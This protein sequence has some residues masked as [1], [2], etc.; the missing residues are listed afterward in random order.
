MYGLL[1]KW[2]AI[3]STLT[4]RSAPVDT[5]VAPSV[6]CVLL[7]LILDTS[8]RKSNHG[9]LFTTSHRILKDV[10][11]CPICSN[12]LTATYERTAVWKIYWWSRREMTCNETDGAR[13]C[14]MWRYYRPTWPHLKGLSRLKSTY[15]TRLAG[16]QVSAPI[17]V[18][19]LCTCDDVAFYRITLIAC[20][21]FMHA[22]CQTQG[23]LG[24][25]V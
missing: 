17:C 2:I 12:S 19:R 6:S 25:G 20:F 8:A 14:L 16:L 15:P 7:D 11:N 1:Y 10:V 5:R 21:P 24:I 4:F 3:R 23:S 9:K 13:K 18:F 22:Y